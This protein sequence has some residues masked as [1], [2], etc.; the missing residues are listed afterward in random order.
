MFPNA[1]HVFATFLGEM[2]AYA[3]DLV[4]I[5]IYYNIGE[6]VSESLFLFIKKNIGENG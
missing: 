3:F 2:S 1:S 4:H 6:G 5:H